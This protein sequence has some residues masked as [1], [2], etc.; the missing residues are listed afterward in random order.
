MTAG[1]TA[2]KVLNFFR[3]P[4]IQEVTKHLELGEMGNFE[5]VYTRLQD[6]HGWHSKA[7]WTLA[8]F[9]LFIL[10]SVPWVLVHAAETKEKVA[11]TIN[12]VK[13]QMFSLESRMSKIEGQ[14]SAMQVALNELVAQK[15]ATDICRT[16]KRSK[17][18]TDPV[19]KNALR[20]ELDAHQRRYQRLVGGDEYPVDRCQ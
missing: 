4:K 11:D 16:L 2:A 3:P 6:V 8:A 12:E 7:A 14:N 18:E 19:E 9:V 15:V 1:T 17:E 13:G 10:F 5:A 20:E